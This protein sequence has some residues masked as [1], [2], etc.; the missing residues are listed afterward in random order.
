MAGQ[1]DYSYYTDD[2][3]AAVTGSMG[4]FS[5]VMSVFCIAIGLIALIAMYK[6][7]KKFGKPGWIAI[8]PIY[9]MWTL[10]ELVGFKGWFSIIPFLNT[11]IYIISLVKLAEKFGKKTGFILGI[12]FF[13]PIFLSILGFSKSMPVDAQLNNNID[14]PVNNVP[15]PLKPYVNE[16]AN[17]STA[18]ADPVPAPVNEP[19]APVEPSPVI[20]TPIPVVQEVQPVNPVITEEP[21]QQFFTEPSPV[22]VQTEPEVNNN[23]QIPVADAFNMKPE[24]PVVPVA[25]VEP[26]A[27]IVQNTPV[28]PIV[29]NTPVE[30][31]VQSTPV[32]PVVPQAEPIN[33]QTSTQVQSKVCPKCGTQVDSNAT[34]C[35]MCGEKF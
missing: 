12:I 34:F 29:Q 7:F 11:I 21:K 20:E 19:V 5:I 15:E 18:S 6:I 24:T 33:P 9:N 8:V 30:P 14:N 10:F 25:P 3:A 26:V 28:E 31:V 1:Y 17:E 22:D 35:F 13:S 2:T 23:V 16:N 32:E 27:P 4:V